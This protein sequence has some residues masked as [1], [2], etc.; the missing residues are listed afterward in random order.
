MIKMIQKLKNKKGFTLV[1]LIVVIAIIAILT[2]VIVPLIARYSA[3]A[4]YTTLQEAASTVSNAANN[5]MSDANQKGVVNTTQ[6]TG[7]KTGTTL[8]IVIGTGSDAVTVNSDPNQTYSN[9]GNTRAAQKL[10]ESLYSTLPDGASFF[11]K[12]KASAVAGVVYTTDH[13]NTP[14]TGVASIHE[15]D[16]FDSAYASG[17]KTGAAIGVSGD[18]L[19]D[20]VDGPG[21]T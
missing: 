21:K 10:W 13:A 9:D 8:T 6:I 1:E 7:N 4:Q 14:A 2:A 5:A 11:I 17:S 19:G 15:V 18:Y 3:Q 16:G 20:G 12:V